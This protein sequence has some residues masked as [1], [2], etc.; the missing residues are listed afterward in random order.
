M[1]FFIPAFFFANRTPIIYFMNQ[2]SK[3]E[4]LYSV[5]DPLLGKD[6]KSKPSWH[7]QRLQPKKETE[8]W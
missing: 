7:K 6:K 2:M 3:E 5:F 1:R 4:D 8:K